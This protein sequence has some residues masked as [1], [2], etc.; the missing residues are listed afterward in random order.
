MD[1]PMDVNEHSVD[2]E[3]DNETIGYDQHEQ[4]I[5]FSFRIITSKLF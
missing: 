3:D 4:V 1:D 5:F 2:D